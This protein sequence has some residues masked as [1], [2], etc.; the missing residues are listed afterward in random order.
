MARAV[1]VL[2]SLVE[3][4]LQV[5]SFAIVLYSRMVRMATDFA[6]SSPDALGGLDSGCNQAD[7]QLGDGF[8]SQRSWSA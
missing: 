5:E 8:L 2:Q 7:K 1:L 3:K 4:E 6:K